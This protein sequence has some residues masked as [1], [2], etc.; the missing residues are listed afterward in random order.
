MTETHTGIAVTDRVR[1]RVADLLGGRDL[2]PADDAT[3]LADL[4]PDRYDSLGV[5][6]CVAAVED[7]FD[8]S[9]DLVDDDLRVTFRSVSSISELV[10][11]RLADAEAL[12]WT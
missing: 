6:D 12:G 9:I 7:E 5:L 4:D 1:A 8:I 2:D 10:R 3:P 11:R